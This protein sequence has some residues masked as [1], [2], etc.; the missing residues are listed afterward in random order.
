MFWRWSRIEHIIYRW[1]F[2]YG[3][4]KMADALGVWH[5]LGNRR[6]ACFLVLTWLLTEYIGHLL[7]HCRWTAGPAFSGNHI[8]FKRIGN[9]KDWNR[10]K[11]CFQIENFLLYYFLKYIWPF[12]KHIFN[13]S[14]IFK[15]IY[16]FIK[17][18]FSFLI[19]IIMLF[20]FTTT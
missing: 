14:V 12:L 16:S 4:N 6:V 7:F 8:E 10:Q 2:R 13:V 20:F 11:N 19:Y 5:V 3:K 18:I 9:L 17:I 15:L 1:G